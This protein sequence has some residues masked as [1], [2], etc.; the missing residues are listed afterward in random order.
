MGYEELR[1]KA[2]REHEK[3]QVGAGG[4]LGELPVSLAEHGISTARNNAPCLLPNNLLHALPSGSNGATAL[5]LSRDGTRG[6]DSDRAPHHTRAQSRSSP[7]TLLPRYR[8]A[9]RVRDPLRVPRRRGDLQHRQRPAAAPRPRAPPHHPRAVLVGG[10]PEAALRLG[11]RLGEAVADDA[12]G[13][14]RGRAVGHPPPPVICLLRQDAAAAAGRPA[15]LVRRARFSYRNSSHRLTRPPA[16]SRYP[17]G[18]CVP[19]ARPPTAR[20]RAPPTPSPLYRYAVEG[21]IATGCNDCGL[22]LWDIATGKLVDQSKKHGARVNACTWNSDGTQVRRP[23]PH[24]PPDPTFRPAS[25]PSL[26]PF[27]AHAALLGR[28]GGRDRAVGRALGLVPPPHPY[29]REERAARRADQLS[30][31]PSEARAPPPRADARPPARLARHPPRQPVGAV[32][33]PPGGPR[34]GGSNTSRTH[35]SGAHP[36][37]PTSHHPAP[38]V[39]HHQVGEYNVRAAY[40]PDG[41]MVVCG[42]EDGSLF[43]WE[44]ESGAVLLDSWAVGL[45]GP[46]LQV[47]WCPHDHVLA[48]CSYGPHNPVLIYFH[49]PEV[50]IK[51]SKEAESRR[52]PPPPPARP[53]PPPPPPRPRRRRRGRRRAAARRRRPARRDARAVPPTRVR[54]L[55]SGIRDDDSQRAAAA[56]TAAVARAQQ[57]ERPA[58]GA[59]RRRRRPTPPKPRASAPAASAVRAARIW[60]RRTRRRRRRWRRATTCRPS[61]S[62]SRRR[63]S[64]RRDGVR[65]KRGGESEGTLSHVK[66]FVQSH[67]HPPEAPQSVPVLARPA[68]RATPP[69]AACSRGRRRAASRT[70]RTPRPGSGSRSGGA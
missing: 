48:C 22:R 3:G 56:A 41:R 30:G 45:N 16:L 29:H 59:G 39:C 69:A 53:R 26:I 11:R 18:L 1:A 55:T 54:G 46:L 7:H 64:R 34:C 5:A 50:A 37:A 57:I 4:A 27:T 19:P 10:R 52:R 17:S 68:P 58:A 70:P 31:R 32:P 21:L 47:A 67:R 14:R 66:R 8:R 43:V 12:D 65:G 2:A 6:R 40:S 24:S 25:D 38:P 60:R 44:E 20:P 13:G 23:P 28:R 49:D 33:R 9:R 62:A 15:Q 42:S 61:A 51:Q 36:A 63:R 35:S